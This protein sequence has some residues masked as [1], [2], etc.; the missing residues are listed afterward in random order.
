MRVGGRKGVYVQE[1][2]VQ[3]NLPALCNIIPSYITV[4]NTRGRSPP[5]HCY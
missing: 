3:T 2:L 1:G 4:R 5:L